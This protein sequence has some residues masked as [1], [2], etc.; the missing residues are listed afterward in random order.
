LFILILTF[1]RDYMK[2]VLEQG[3]NYFFYYDAVSSIV[4]ILERLSE[5]KDLIDKV[6]KLEEVHV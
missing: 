1:T 4:L 5:V 6:K 2:A 3:I